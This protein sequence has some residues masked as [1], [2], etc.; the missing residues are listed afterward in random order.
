VDDIIFGAANQMS[1][2]EFS[3]I[4]FQKFEMSVMGELKFFL[5]FQVKQLKD[6]TFISQTKYM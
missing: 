1:C 6:D 2:E 4:L 3:R 5:G